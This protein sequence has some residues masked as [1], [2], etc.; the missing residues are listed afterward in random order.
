MPSIYQNPVS[1][2][3]L[4]EVIMVTIT[5]KNRVRPLRDQGRGVLKADN[6]VADMELSNVIRQSLIDERQS[7]E[8]EKLI[9]ILREVVQNVIYGKSCQNFTGTHIHELIIG[10]RSRNG[11]HKVSYIVFPHFLSMSSKKI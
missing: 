11:L 5:H 10:R 7:L 3:A 8:K 2:Y 6:S 9:K 4:S 1:E